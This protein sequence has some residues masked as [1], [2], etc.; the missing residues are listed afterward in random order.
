MAVADRA[1]LLEVTDRWHQHARRSRHRLDDHRRD[2]LGAALRDDRLEFVRQVRAVLRLPAREEILLDAMRVRHV[3][4]V[5][6]EL[7][8][9][10]G[11]R[12]RNPANGDA[13]E[14]HAVV[15]ALAPDKT[16]ALRL[17]RARASMRARS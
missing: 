17:S 15:R 6:Q 11:A 2:R 9:E 12:V 5:R 1:Q 13:T 14:A 3:I 4:D 8:L 16:H 7:R 10:R